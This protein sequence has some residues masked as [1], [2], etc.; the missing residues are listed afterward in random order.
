M[1]T[2]EATN[3]RLTVRPDYG[4]F[5]LEVNMKRL[6]LQV[7]L[8]CACCYGQEFDVASIGRTMPDS[9]QHMGGQDVPI[10][11]VEPTILRMRSVTL[12]AVIKW[13]YNLRAHELVGKDGEQWNESMGMQGVYYIEGHFDPSTSRQDIRVMLQNLLKERMG[14]VSHLEEKQ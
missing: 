4:I 8:I 6:A 12:A 14:L 11:M 7:F 2:K 10:I 9:M 3:S 13:A 1:K 5:S